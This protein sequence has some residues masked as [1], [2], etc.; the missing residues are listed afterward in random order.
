MGNKVTK[1]SIVHKVKGKILGTLM[2]LKWHSL[3]AWRV[4]EVRAEGDEIQVS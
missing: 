3:D 2:I 4:V 1:I